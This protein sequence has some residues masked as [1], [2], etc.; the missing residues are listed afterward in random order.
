MLESK[1]TFRTCGAVLHDNVPFGPAFAAAAAGCGCG[2][3]DDD[4]DAVEGDGGCRIRVLKLTPAG[5]YVK[6]PANPLSTPCR[7]AP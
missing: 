3:D 7:F 2:S 1:G 5:E 6:L 4:D